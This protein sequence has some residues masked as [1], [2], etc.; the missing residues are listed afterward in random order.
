MCQRFLFALLPC[1][2]KSAACTV[3]QV[4]SAVFLLLEVFAGETAEVDLRKDKA[5][6]E[7]RPKFL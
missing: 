7:R 3:L 6:C 1:S 2:K 4:I 5:V